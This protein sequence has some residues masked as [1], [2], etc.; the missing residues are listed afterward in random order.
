M[1]ATG[2]Y[3]R[4]EAPVEYAEPIFEQQF[5]AGFEEPIRFIYSVHSSYDAT[6]QPVQS[7]HSL[8]DGEWLNVR[9][10][11]WW[12]TAVEK[13]FDPTQIAG[14][15]GESVSTGHRLAAVMAHPETAVG[16]R[17]GRVGPMAQK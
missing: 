1:R 4:C 10:R 7:M 2:D 11:S 8:D 3:V 12:V 6:A 5:D 15:N 9:R 14:T 13:P 16:V 17:R